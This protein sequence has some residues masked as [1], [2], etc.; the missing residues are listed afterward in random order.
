MHSVENRYCHQVSFDTEKIHESEKE[1]IEISCL[2]K[3]SLSRKRKIQLFRNLGNFKHNQK[4]FEE[5][6]SLLV[7]Q[8]PV[9]DITTNMDKYVCCKMCLGFNSKRDIYRHACSTEKSV[10]KTSIKSSSFFFSKHPIL[11][12]FFE[13]MRNNEIAKIIRKD[14]ILCQFVTQQLLRKGFK[15]YQVISNQVRLVAQ[16]IQ[17]LRKETKNET[18]NLTQLLTPENFDNLFQGILDMFEY[19]PLTSKYQHSVVYVKSPSSLIKLCQFPKFW[20]HCKFTI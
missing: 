16:M 8:R 10:V 5:G 15:K 4:V 20:R 1:V 17:T 13:R 2:P 14:T 19:N 3:L 12:K 7:V 11:A 6:G 9:N 18:L